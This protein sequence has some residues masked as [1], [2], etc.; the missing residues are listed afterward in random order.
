MMMVIACVVSHGPH[1][2]LEVMNEGRKEGRKEG[3]QSQ[4]LCT[5]HARHLDGDKKQ[6]TWRERRGLSVASL[7]R[8]YL[9]VGETTWRTLQ[10]PNL[11]IL[12]GV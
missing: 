11:D 2:N 9:G 1:G 3:A 7:F 8:H 4:H 12:T 6:P 10:I 5:A